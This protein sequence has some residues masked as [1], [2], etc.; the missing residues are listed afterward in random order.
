MNILT[1]LWPDLI[2]LALGVVFLN[3]AITGKFYTHRRGGGHKLIVSVS[4]SWVRVMFLFIAAVIV[5]WLVYDLNHK[6]RLRA[7]PFGATLTCRLGI[8]QY[9]SKN[10][11]G[12]HVRLAES[13][14]RQFLTTCVV[15]VICPL[16]PRT[17]WTP[18]VV[19]TSSFF[20]SADGEG[21][22]A[23]GQPDC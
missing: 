15:A 7:A 19:R 18:V 6:M 12:L 10:G 5:A 8:Y 4:S 9:D 22:D 21:L 17:P 20:R 11:P 3:G 1:A 2:A 13:H 16:A 23:K 14:L